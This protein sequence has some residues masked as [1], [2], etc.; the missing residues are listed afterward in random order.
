MVRNFKIKNLELKNVVDFCMFQ[1]DEN[2]MK[3]NI[4]K[5]L[6][7][8]FSFKPLKLKVDLF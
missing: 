4:Y 8:I 1:T 5:K 6:L 3:H 7:Q 2:I